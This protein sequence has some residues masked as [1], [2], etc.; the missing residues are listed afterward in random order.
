[1]ESHRAP[2]I[3]QQLRLALWCGLT[4]KLYTLLSR[5]EATKIKIEVCWKHSSFVIPTIDQ[6]AFQLAMDERRLTLLSV[7]I[8]Q[9]A[10]SPMQPVSIPVDNMRLA[11]HEVNLK[12]Y[13]AVIIA[14]MLMTHIVRVKLISH[15]HRQTLL[16]KCSEPMNLS[17]DHVSY[18][19]D[20]KVSHFA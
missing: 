10:T 16:H 8:P 4:Y 13:I 1:M 9:S 19:P 6:K 7:P 3:L 14:V 17:S 2:G 20:L 5:V 18:S 11:C 12:G 15:W